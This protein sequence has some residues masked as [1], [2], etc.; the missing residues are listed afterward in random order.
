MSKDKYWLLPEGVDESL[1]YEA[2]GIE[3]LRRS[4]LDNFSRWGYQL[5]IPPIIEYVDSLLA[6]GAEDLDL[7]TFKVVDR[8][9]GRLIG[10]RADMTP[11]LTRID[12]HRMPT[13]SPQRLCYAGPVAHTFSEK[14]AGSR[15]PLQIGAELFGHSGVESDAEIITLLVNS[16]LIANIRSLTLE[17][18]HIG[19]FRGICAAASFT[20]EFEDQVLEALVKKDRTSLTEML[21]GE[22][23]DSVVMTNLLL[24]IDLNGD[25]DI[26][27][28]ARKKFSGLPESVSEAIEELAALCDLLK[29]FIPEVELHVD[30]AELRGYRYHSGIMFAAYVPEMGRSIAW[31]GRYDGVQKQLGRDRGAT[32]FSTDLRILEQFLEKDERFE[33]VVIAPSGNDK[34]LLAAMGR[35]RKEGYTVIQSLPGQSDE[36]N[37][38]SIEFRL[39]S[40]NDEWILER[41][42]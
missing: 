2:S 6:G 34:K 9:T 37:Q 31:G 13:K 29:Q 11:Q 12:T 27:N 33:T 19:I 14:F 39:V 32:G 30:L 36:W 5:V 21:E 23:V 26:I 42:K 4:M 20:H 40:R 15:N 10:L 41:S 1:P 7:Q 28:E 25:L 16:L 3:S 38:L 22:G 8:V 24:L 17:V 18:T 35:Y